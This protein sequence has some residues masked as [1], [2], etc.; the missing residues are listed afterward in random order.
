MVV[1]GIFK[2]CLF[3]FDDELSLEIISNQRAE[4]LQRILAVLGI[5]KRGKLARLAVT[6]ITMHP[7]LTPI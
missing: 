1:S 3:T 4:T 7:R 2:I 6:I 5:K